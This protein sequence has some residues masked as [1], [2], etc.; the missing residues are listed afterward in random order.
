M[1]KSFMMKTLKVLKHRISGLFLNLPFIFIFIFIL[2]NAVTSAAP[3][4]IPA[5]EVRPA[6]FALSKVMMHDVVSPTI[7]SRYYMYATLGAACILS[8]DG[9]SFPHPS[10]YIRHLPDSFG[11]IPDDA[12]PS[13]TALFCIY[14]TGM[15]MLPSGADVQSDYDAARGRLRKLGY[16]DREMEAA[17]LAAASVATSVLAYAAADG[18][19]LLSRYP[20]YRPRKKEGFWFP[21]PPAYME[22]SD[23]HWGKMRT[24]VLDSA[25]QFKSA[26]PVPFDTTAGSDFQK[27]MDEVR[28][29]GGSPTPEQ[30]EIA[31][32]WDCNPFVIATSGHMTLGF[33]KISP[34][35]HW[36]NIA[37]LAAEIRGIDIDRTLM[38]AFL[39]AVTLYDAFIVCWTEKYR[40]D[41]VRPESVIHRYM[42]VNWQPMLQTPPFPEYTSGHSVI[43]SASA[44]V[45][46]FLLGD[47]LAYSDDTEVMFELPVR[48]FTSFR[49]AAREAS[50]SR[51][52]FRDAIEQGQATGISIGLHVVERIRQAGMSGF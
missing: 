52:H 17:S 45:L 39:E 40:T 3:R 49:H 14:E 46:S 24:M 1:I 5:Q 18:Y 29:V 7:A 23:P 25:G 30:R 33:K 13:L 42:D 36:M 19:D 50:I 44:E 31:G 4:P 10:S 38:T 11:R 8:R 22:A 37:C 26:P 51:I 41:R 34:G 12:H 20:R 43:S 21:T 16:S 27:L 15:R 6:I 28:L 9:R 48:H 32:F 47:S 35:G 2:N